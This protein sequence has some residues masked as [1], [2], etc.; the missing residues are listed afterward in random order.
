[1][2]DDSPERARSA[3]AAAGGI[4]AHPDALALLAAIL[5]E[6]RGLRADIRRD[7]HLRALRLAIVDEFADG[8]FTVRG[9]LEI[10]DT[11][12]DN[13]LAG[14]LAEV[15]DLAAPD[16]SRTTALGRLLASVP[17]LEVRGETRG[18]ALY[19]VADLGE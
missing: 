15:V 16:R 7:V 5:A 3:A 18:S 8:G 12:P 1:M 11:E 13:A 4:E 10:A 14:A 2:R 19:R 6:V 9:L 17:W